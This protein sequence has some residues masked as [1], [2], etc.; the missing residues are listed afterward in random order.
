MKSRTR[1]IAPEL[2]R[3]IPDT[4]IRPPVACSGMETVFGFLSRTEPDTLEFLSDPRRALA[5]WEADAERAST[6]WVRIPT[7]LHEPLTVGVYPTL[8][9]ELIFPVNP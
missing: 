5:E 9:L 4:L 1:H 2:P 8:S 3:E 7:G 6:A